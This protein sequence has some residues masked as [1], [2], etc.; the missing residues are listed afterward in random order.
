MNTPSENIINSIRAQ[1]PALGIS[2]GK[3]K[4]VYLD[5]TATSQTP[6]RVVEAI[7]R[8]YYNTK[9]NVHRGVH[10]LSQQMTLLQEEAREKARAFINAPSV[11]EIIF[12]RGTTEAINLVASCIGRDWP[13]GAEVIVTEMEHHSNIVPWQLLS[14]RTH[15]RTRR[16]RHEHLPQP[17]QQQYGHGSSHTRKQRAW[18]RKPRKGNRG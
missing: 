11:Q 1:F 14:R 10:T 13:D 15:R 18:H 5:N 8:A 7:D 9:A 2:V 3:H 6:Q 4:L 16:A 12:T 17:F